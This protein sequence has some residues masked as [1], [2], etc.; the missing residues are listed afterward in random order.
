MLG[1]ITPGTYNRSHTVGK[2]LM[3][4]Y[5]EQETPR[6]EYSALLYPS[7]VTVMVVLDTSPFFNL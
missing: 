1:I 2:A 4:S 3:L 7:L 6:H 5:L